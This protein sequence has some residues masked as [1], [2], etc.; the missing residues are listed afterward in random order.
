MPQMEI[1]ASYWSSYLQNDVLCYQ[2]IILQTL[3]SFAIRS[4]GS[5]WTLAVA[6]AYVPY[7]VVLTT[8]YLLPLKLALLS[9]LLE[10]SRKHSAAFVAADAYICLHLMIELLH[11]Q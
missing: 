9:Q 11:L 6:A 1:Q 7:V 8:I 5:T 2:G 10:E 3:N 4:H